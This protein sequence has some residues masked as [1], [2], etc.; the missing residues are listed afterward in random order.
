[1]ISEE[2]F[3]GIDEAP[4]LVMETARLLGYVISHE[5]A[6]EIARQYPDQLE[7]AKV[8]EAALVARGYPEGPDTYNA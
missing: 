2:P 6:K 3:K 5:E 7:N 4:E 1:M 8:V